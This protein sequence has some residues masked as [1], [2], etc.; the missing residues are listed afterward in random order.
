MKPDSWLPFYGNDFFQAVEGY[1][2]HTTMGYLRCLWHYWHHSHCAG[3]INDD[4]FL[5]RLC[6]CER[7]N[8]LR[9]KG[10]IFDGDKL[11]KLID[12]KWHQKR[13]SSEY[14][15]SVELYEKRLKASAAGV[16]ARRNKP[17]VQPDVDQTTTTTTT[18]TTGTMKTTLGSSVEPNQ[19][20]SQD[21]DSDWVTS[22]KSNSAYQGIDVDRELG[23][24][25]SWCDVT[26]KTPSRRRF[27]NWLNRVDKPIV[28]TS[29]KK[30]GKVAA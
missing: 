11:F 24:M 21:C 20:K 29:T 28:I 3:L 14:T 30:R 22:L 2:D 27:V 6:R 18:I 26:K 17:P 4:D 19:R 15:N 9:T 12:G 16:D 25:L 1:D 23:R 8:W 5:R 10:M 13:A 7:E